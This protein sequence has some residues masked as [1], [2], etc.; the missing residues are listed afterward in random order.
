[1]DTVPVAT[2]VDFAEQ[3]IFCPALVMKV[4]EEVAKHA[5]GDDPK[6]RSVYRSK[7]GVILNHPSL[8]DRLE[9]IVFPPINAVD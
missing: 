5:F 7:L 4:K 1:M 3:N 6:T 2:V 9:N 8:V